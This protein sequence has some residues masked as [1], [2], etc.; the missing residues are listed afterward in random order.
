MDTF[1][2]TITGKRENMTTSVCMGIYNGEKYIEQQMNSI[3]VQSRSVDEVIL[4]DDG[5]KDGTVDIVKR[6]IREHKLEKHW[7]L[8][9]NTTNKGYPANFYYAMGLCTGDIVFLADQDDI[10]SANKVERMCNIFEEYKEAAGLCCKFS[11]IDDQNHKIRSVMKPVRS[12]ESGQIR[13]VFIDD[14]FY[15]Y[16]WPGMAMA[17]RRAWY[18]QKLQEWSAGGYDIGQL[19]IPHDLF[20]AAWAADDKE[21]LQL[22]E[23]LVWHRRHTNNVGEEE[24]R[25]HKL[26]NKDRKVWE[27]KKYLSNLDQLKKYEVI[28]TQHGIRT[29]NQK[30][31]VLNG[32][33]DAMMSGSVFQTIKNAWRNRKDTR[34]VTFICDVLIAIKD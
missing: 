18:E 14:V 5:S 27:I 6:F 12:T 16:E 29:L 2:G 9:Q 28:K 22:D 26:I 7:K 21:F 20:I 8:Y 13:R 3:L 31:F 25:I 11:L 33:L 32:R 34:I 17:Y 30:Y 15:K 23:E 4:C 19:K 10:W 24:H 1:E